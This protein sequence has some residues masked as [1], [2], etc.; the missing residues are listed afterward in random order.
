[1]NLPFFAV[2]AYVPGGVQNQAEQNSKN[3]F[4]PVP[5]QKFTFPEFFDIFRRPP[6]RLFL[7]FFSILGPEV[8]ETPVNGRSGRNTKGH[9]PS[10]DR[11][12]WSH[13]N[14]QFAYGVLVA[15]CGWEFNRGPGRCWESRSLSRFCFALV[16]KGFWHYSTTI[17]R[18]SPPSGLERGGWELPPVRGCEIGWDRALPIALP[19]AEWVL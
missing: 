14:R 9:T 1:M 6:K 13:L 16:L 15:P 19:I 8:P 12:K 2:K 3:A 18:L 7:R 10:L 5:V 4:R 11:P 17:V